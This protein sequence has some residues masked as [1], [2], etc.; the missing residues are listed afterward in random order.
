[1]TAFQLAPTCSQLGTVQYHGVEKNK[2]SHLD[3]HANLN[4]ELLQRQ[5]V[6][7]CGC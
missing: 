5:L 6:R 2:T 3:P 7:Q 4:I 1:M